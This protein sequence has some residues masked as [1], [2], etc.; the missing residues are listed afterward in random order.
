MQ[1]MFE[2]KTRLGNNCNFKDRIPKYFTS[3]VIYK[4]K[5]GLCHDSYMMN[6]WD[7]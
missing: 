3:G 5:S 1:I 7:N 6:V 2:N 4:F